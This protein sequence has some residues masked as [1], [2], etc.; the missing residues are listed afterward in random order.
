MAIDPKTVKTNDWGVL[1]CA[2][3]IFILSFFSAYITASSSNQLGDFSVGVN[4][5]HGYAV[6]GLL[7]LF[8]AAAIVAAR[9]F[10]NVTL[11]SLPVGWNLVIAVLAG[12]G[13]LLVILRA[14]TGGA[15]GPGFSVGP[16][17]SGWAIMI[18]AVAETVFAAMTFRESGEKVQ[19]DRPATP[20]NPQPPP[21]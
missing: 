1:A 10:A 12:L 13:A 20:S 8:A 5:W 11:P 15:S 14:L 16:G 7:L 4:A 17:W 21:A 19:W 18:L 3:L 9:V 6:L 2:G